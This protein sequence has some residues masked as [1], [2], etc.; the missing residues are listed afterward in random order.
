MFERAVAWLRVGSGN[1]ALRDADGAKDKTL[2]AMRA[3]PCL[4][5]QG[6]E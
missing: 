2:A 4:V 1:W 6:K 3:R 5:R